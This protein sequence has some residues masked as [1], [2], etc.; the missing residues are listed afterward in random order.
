MPADELLVLDVDVIIPAAL[1]G[2]ITKHNAGDVRARYVI[3]A[4]NHPTEPEADD[5]LERKGVTVMPDIYVNAGGVTV[6]YMEW[7]QNIQ[8]YRWDEARVND[9]LHAIMTRAYQ[10]VKQA[11]ATH[12]C[13]WR[14]AAFALAV[15][16]VAHTTRLRGVG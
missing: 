13:S 5:I 7:A 9:E 8:Q 3:E 15:S 6:S 12:G 10:Q 4:A 14:T 1:G 11:R 2:V 16:R